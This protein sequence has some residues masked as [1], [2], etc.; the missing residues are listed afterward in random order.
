MGQSRTNILYLSLQDPFLGGGGA[1]AHLRGLSQCL[2]KLGCEVHILVLDPFKDLRSSSRNVNGVQMHYLRLPFARALRNALVVGSLHV[3]S[4]FSFGEVNRL[5]RKYKI[6]IIHS[7]SPSGYGY[8]LLRRG[9]VPFVSTLHS[10]SFGEFLSYLD[11]PI[12]SINGSLIYD[13]MF[14]LIYAFQTNIEYKT[15]DKV[16]AVSY[17][18]AEEAVR[19][20]HLPRNRVIAIHNGVNLPNLLNSYAKKENKEQIILAIGRLCWSKGHKYLVDAMPAVLSEFPSARLLLVGDGNQR[21]ALQLQAKKLGIKNAV[22]FLGRVSAEKLRLLYCDADVFVHPSLYDPFP[23]AVLEAMSMGKSVVATHVGGIPE[24]ITNG[25]DGLLVEPRN[26]FELARAITDIL[27][28]SSSSRRLGQEA[29]KR[30][31]KEFTWEAIA[32]KTLEFYKSLL[33]EKRTRLDPQ[34]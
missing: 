25:V 8:G 17:A 32:R 19:F 15:A 3:P 4:S 9:D 26:S 30:I 11:V 21:S 31:E 27:S 5:C 1:D 23:I 6:D 20:F 7:Q 24:M 18:T 10:T 34:A 13:S 33:S 28:D 22:G 16:I 2:E 12:S 29:R 14:E